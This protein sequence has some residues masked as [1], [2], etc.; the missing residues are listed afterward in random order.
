MLPRD[1]IDNPVN[2]RQTKERGCFV[3]KTKMKIKKRY[4]IK[5]WTHLQKL[6]KPKKESLL[7][8]RKQTELPE[9][10][11][12]KNILKNNIANA[13]NIDLSVKIPSVKARQ[14]L[15]TKS[16]QSMD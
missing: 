1:K 3:K 11:I 7:L 2:P 9:Y 8:S 16:Y 5:L 12:A 4:I 14:T 15:E 6:F 13:T 10:A